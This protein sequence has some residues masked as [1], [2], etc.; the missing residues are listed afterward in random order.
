MITAVWRK[1]PG[2]AKLNL[3][4]DIRRGAQLVTEIENIGNADAPGP[5]GGVRLDETYITHFTTQ[6][7][8]ETDSA[9]ADV[10]AHGTTVWVASQGP[11]LQRALI[12]RR[13]GLG[14][15]KVRVFDQRVDREIEPKVPIKIALRELTAE[16][17]MW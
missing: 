7:P 16:Q 15:G 4:R 6:A 2:R 9:V 1:P 13:L 12:A 3:E 14:A 11:H 17:V 10:R 5:G 8:L